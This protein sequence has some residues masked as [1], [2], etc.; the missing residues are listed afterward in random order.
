MNSWF[1]YMPLIMFVIGGLIYLYARAGYRG[2]RGRGHGHGGTFDSGSYDR[3]THDLHETEP[4]NPAA[5]IPA[6]VDPRDAK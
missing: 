6:A 4:V 3:G 5:Q 2:S 1:L